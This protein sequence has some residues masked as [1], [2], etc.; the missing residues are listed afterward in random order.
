VRVTFT[1]FAASH[2]RYI[3]DTLQ[4]LAEDG[5]MKLCTTLRDAAF[6]NATAGRPVPFFAFVVAT[7][8]RYLVGVDEQGSPIMIKDPR[9][10]ELQ[11]LARACFGVTAADCEAQIEA[12]KLSLEN[13]NGD[14]DGSQ[15]PVKAPAEPP[16]ALLELVFGEELSSIAAVAAAVH[17]SCVEVATTSTRAAMSKLLA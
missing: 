14:G 4:R 10:T 3:K 8:F 16:V 13:G 6:E 11:P 5:S 12:Y 7:W 15:W 17:T 1:T 9:L 2:N